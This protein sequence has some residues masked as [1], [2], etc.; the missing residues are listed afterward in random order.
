MTMIL[1]HRPLRVFC[2]Y[3]HK[4]EQ[5]FTELWTSLA[6]VRQ[7]GLIEGWHDRQISPG[8]D[9]DQ[10]IDEN[11]NTSDIVLL[12]VTPDFINSE[13]IRKKEITRA[14]E[15]HERDEAR[16]IP[17]IVRYAD[18]EWAPFGRLQALP[19]DAKPIVAWQDRDE[20]WLDVVRGVRKAI[21]ELRGKPSARRPQIHELD[22]L[23][24]RESLVRYREEYQPTP[25][26]VKVLET[27][28]QTAWLR[29][30]EKGLEY[31]LDDK[32][33][34][35]GSQ[36]W[37]LERAEANDVLSKQNYRVD[38]EYTERGGL[39]DVGPRKNW[40]YSKRLYPEPSLLEF[41]IQRLLEKAST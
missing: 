13:Y 9:W 32:R 39:F 27:P 28:N 23:T 14:L 29:V 37:T 12:L 7:Q 1:A 20:A 25:T 33:P 6:R 22:N 30:T 5:Y 2:S 11:L 36:R 21:E 3:S 8:I 24:D 41:E 16:V 19:K 35:R 10:A 34:G 4:D 40:I 15:K 38:P 31:H 18:W 17:I 26:Q